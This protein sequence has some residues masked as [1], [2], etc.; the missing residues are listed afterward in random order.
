MEKHLWWSLSWCDLEFGFKSNNDTTKILSMALNWKFLNTFTI[1]MLI[2]C[3][4][5]EPPLLYTTHPPYDHPLLYI[6]FF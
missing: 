1:A 6:F 5:F 4:R 3:R 2:V